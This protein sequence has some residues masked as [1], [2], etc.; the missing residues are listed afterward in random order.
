MTRVEGNGGPNTLGGHDPV[1]GMLQR[2]AEP[3]AALAHL[4]SHLKRINDPTIRENLVRRAVAGVKN[5]PL[6]PEQKTALLAALDQ[7]HV[8]ASGDRI[9]AEKDQANRKW[10][11]ETVK[12]DRPGATLL[13]D[14]N[15]YT[16]RSL[17]TLGRMSTAE[18]TSTFKGST[19]QLSDA[20]WGK[21][22]SMLKDR[23][24]SHISGAQTAV[25]WLNG[26][27]TNRERFWQGLKTPAARQR[28]L[29]SLGF[30]AIDARLISKAAHPDHRALR[31]A[32]RRLGGAL[33]SSLERVNHLN[34]GVLTHDDAELFRSYGKEAEKVKKVLGIEA[35]SFAQDVLDQRWKAGKQAI[36]RDAMIASVLG[37]SCGF[38]AGILTSLVFGG[39]SL[40][41]QRGEVGAA[42]IGEALGLAKGGSAAAA[43]ADLRSAQFGAA[44]SLAGASVTTGLSYLS[45]SAGVVRML[46]GEN[47]RAT[48]AVQRGARALDAGGNVAIGVYTAP[49][50]PQ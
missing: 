21:F 8:K 15:L 40:M 31:A 12:P 29:R 5:A 3:E 48:L 28:E 1:E 19:R 13:A 22:S 30:S 11:R 6:S 9:T 4:D 39:L 35:K 17:R 47:A 25:R 2:S 14:P 7:R 44:L 24:V 16:S 23:I 36:Y 32:L 38:G 33:G 50:A 41:A 45:R 42:E 18:V 27:D 43:R 34:P 20:V 49:R 26:S 46:G 37:I 10:L